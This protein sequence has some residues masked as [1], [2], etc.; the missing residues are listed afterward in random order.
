[1]SRKD[2]E[3]KQIYSGKW[4]PETSVEHGPN[5]LGYEGASGMVEVF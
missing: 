4:S 2:K 1:M 3:E 5:I